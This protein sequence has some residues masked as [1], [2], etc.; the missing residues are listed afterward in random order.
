MVNSVSMAQKF[1]RGIMM[2]L[3][4]K[5]KYTLAVQRGRTELLQKKQKKQAKICEYV[6]DS[7]MI[8]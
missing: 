5:Q 6:F 2:Q 7:Q 4:Q 8:G 1:C 3:W